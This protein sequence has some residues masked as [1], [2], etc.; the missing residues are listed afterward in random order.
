MPVYI[1]LLQSRASGAHAGRLHRHALCT[2]LKKKFKLD[3]FLRAKWIS[4]SPHHVDAVAQ[5]PLQRAE[6]LPFQ[7]VNGIARGVGLGNDAAAQAPAPALVMALRAGQI[8]LPHA[9][10]VALFATLLIGCEAGIIRWCD[11]YSAR[12]GY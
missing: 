3:E 7:P 5:A 6:A 8:E 4:L 1:P 9:L 2:L 10:L 12:P 11:G